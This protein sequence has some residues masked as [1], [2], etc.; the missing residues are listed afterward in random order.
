MQAD[1]STVFVRGLPYSTTDS[2]LEAFFEDVG[3]VRRGFVVTDKRLLPTVKHP[4]AN[5]CPRRTLPVA[6]LPAPVDPTSTNRLRMTALAFANSR[7]PLGSDSND[8]HH[9]RSR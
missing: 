6:D 1:S 3:P 9:R 5:G 7:M 2:R 8:E 4:V